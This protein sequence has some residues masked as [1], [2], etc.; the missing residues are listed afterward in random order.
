MKNFPT[1]AQTSRRVSVG[2]GAALPPRRAS[3]PA[4]RKELEEFFGLYA[5]LEKERDRYKCESQTY[6]SDVDRLE[7]QVK[8]MDWRCKEYQARLNAA[9]EDIGVT[10]AQALPTL[11]ESLS[12]VAQLA[13]RAFPRLVITDQALKTAAEYHQCKCVCEAWEILRHLSEALHP[14]K[15]DE[16]EL[17]LE[18]AFRARTGYV[19]SMRE[20][21]QTQADARLMRLRRL[22]HGEQE[23]DMTP[24]VKHGTQEPRL[25]RIHFNF[26]EPS[27][28]I[29]VGHIGRHLPNYTTKKMM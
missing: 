8:S 25:V 1:Q 13:R 15:F 23:Y 19:L 10:V 12:D 20:G 5:E 3:D 6:A 2:N 9:R 11:P 7:A 17:D 18:G 27:R 28:R 14:L 29:V 21:K 24:H 26:D 22:Q 16:R 4:R